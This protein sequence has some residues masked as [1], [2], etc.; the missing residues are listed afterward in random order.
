MYQHGYAEDKQDGEVEL[1]YV[2]DTNPNS[3]TISITDWGAPF[4][5]THYDVANDDDVDEVTGMG[6]AIALANVDDAAYVRDG[7]RNV[8]AFRKEW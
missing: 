7:D 8:V 2:Y 4:D 3:L 1:S 6:I 5:P